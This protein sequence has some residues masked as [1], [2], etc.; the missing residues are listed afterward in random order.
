[1][2]K[3]RQNR[4]DYIIMR[5]IILELVVSLSMRPT[6]GLDGMVVRHP[7]FAS[8]DLNPDP[9]NRTAREANTSNLS[10]RFPW[11]SLPP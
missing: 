8:F 11:L 4:L 10:S 2:A 6:S 5:A 7:F 9:S 3:D 1:M